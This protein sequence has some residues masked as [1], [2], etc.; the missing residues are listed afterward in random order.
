M[1]T[2]WRILRF[3]NTTFNF[4][5]D[6]CM[7]IGWNV[8][9]KAHS[10]SKPSLGIYLPTSGILK[11][12]SDHQV[13]GIRMKEI[14]KKALL[15]IILRHNNSQPKHLGMPA[16]ST[17]F[18]SP[19]TSLATFPP[20]SLILPPWSQR[21]TWWQPHAMSEWGVEGVSHIFEVTMIFDT[22]KTSYE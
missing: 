6:V 18:V 2:V 13:P 12:I 15:V 11:K 10:L 16:I 17:T 8:V 9:N 21:N 5:A 22:K 20:L 19:L 3:C 4:K 1:R 14:R 7:I